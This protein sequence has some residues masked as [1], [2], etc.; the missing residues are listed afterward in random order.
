VIAPPARLLSE[1]REGGS[2]LHPI[3]TPGEARVPCFPGSRRFSRRLR[4]RL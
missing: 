4:S 3:K 2:D 1:Y